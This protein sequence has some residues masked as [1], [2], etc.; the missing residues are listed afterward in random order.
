MRLSGHGFHCL[1]GVSGSGVRRRGQRDGKKKLL[2]PAGRR[3]K[4]MPDE[5]HY[6]RIIGHFATGV[7]VVTSLGP[8]GGP[9]GLTANSVTSVSLR[10]PLILVCLDR[11]AFTRDRV[12]ETGAFAVSILRAHETETA[13]RFAQ[14]DRD[15]RF[16]GIVHRRERTG[17][18]I[19]EGALAWLD[20]RVHDVH[21]AGDHS[22]VIGEVIASDA[23]EG[24]PL[25]FFRGSYHGSQT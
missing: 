14:E 15:S 6:R 10:P 23:A 16:E 25:V 7:T 5:L 8:D 12:V 4:Q 9:C 1:R 21:E 3:K 22:V 18:P 11:G 24:E 2:Q 20:C 17:C 19:L 13:R